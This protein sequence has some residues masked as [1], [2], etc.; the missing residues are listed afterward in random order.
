M[1]EQIDY[2]TLDEWAAGVETAWLHHKRSAW[3]VA[4]RVQD[5]ID[6]YTDGSPREVADL[7]SM[8]SE[9]L[10]VSPKTLT[11]YARVA[12]AFPPE[13]R[14]ESLELGHHEVVVKFSKEE[15]AVWLQA[16]AEQG[17]TVKRLRL[18]VNVT[19][20]TEPGEP[21][22]LPNR[23]AIERAFYRVGVKAHVSPKKFRFELPGGTL[24]ATSDT[25]ITW[26]VL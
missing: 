20:S 14:W 8:L 10:E 1:L 23:V 13:E 21:V 25:D 16:A 9:Q 3:D 2:R 18:E 17:W 26:G 19:D 7:L 12:K 24:V 22:P 6:T 5:G 15:R 4:E 11:N